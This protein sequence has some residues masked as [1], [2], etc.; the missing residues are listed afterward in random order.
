LQI[1]AQVNPQEEEKQPAGTGS[2]EQAE[3][4]AGQENEEVR[5]RQYP[6]RGGD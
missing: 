2:Q 1:E 4:N 5:G 3:G 6:Y